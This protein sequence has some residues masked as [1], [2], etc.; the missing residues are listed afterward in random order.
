M[1][2]LRM[3]DR[4]LLLIITEVLEQEVWRQFSGCLWK[5]WEVCWGWGVGSNNR[6][7][8]RRG[9]KEESQGSFGKL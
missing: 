8:S 9:K 6:K 7:M 1:I 2:W 4:Y 5:K 3:S